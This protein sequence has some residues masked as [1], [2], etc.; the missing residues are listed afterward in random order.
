MIPVPCP[1]CGCF[2]CHIYDDTYNEDRLSTDYDIR[3]GSWTV[4]GGALFPTSA[5]SFIICNTAMPSGM[6]TLVA[7]TTA[8][9]SDTSERARLVFL[10]TDDDTYWFSELSSDGTNNLLKLYQRASASNT[11]RGSTQTLDGTA[12]SDTRLLVCVTSGEVK[13]K[14]QIPGQAAE[15]VVY[16]ASTTVAG[17]KCGF[18]AV[19]ST[20]FFVA[21]TELTMDRH[22]D[23]TPCTANCDTYVPGDCGACNGADP[24]TSAWEVEIPTLTNN[25]C[26]DC[27]DFAG[28]YNLSAADIVS[29]NPSEGWCVWEMDITNHC[30]SSV[31][32]LRVHAFIVS[33]P[34]TTFTINV[35]IVSDEVSLLWSIDSSDIG[36][37]GTCA[38]FNE[39]ELPSQN[40][41][42]APCETS[43][44]VLLTAQ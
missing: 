32:I 23:E 13:A 26:S 42:S 12:F 4:S 1:D 14:A 6:T 17:T 24:P 33:F 31:A 9:V 2:E 28:I 8:V 15:E 19:R 34:S 43:D 18:H 3:T 10:Y 30:G 16:S 5:T 11:Q 38:A 40:V 20:D 41:G 36:W 21:F 29:I 35:Q 7:G 39:T 27:A 22:E 44:P 25:G 37:P